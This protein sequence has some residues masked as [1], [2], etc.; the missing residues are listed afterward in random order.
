MSTCNICSTNI[1]KAKFP[2]VKCAGPCENTFHL[3]CANISDEL[4]EEIKNR[5][6]TWLCHACRSNTP[7]QSLIVDEEENY[8]STNN[9]PNLSDVM[10]LLQRMEKKLIALENM[11][12]MVLSLAS[13]NEQLTSRVNTL[14]K[15]L[16]TQ[17]SKIHLLEAEN[18]KPNQQSNSSSI[19]IIGLPSQHDDVRDVVINTIK[20]IG[21]EINYDDIVS[22]HAIPK[23]TSTVSSKQNK[24]N[25][26][27]HDLLVVKFTTNEIK[28]NIMLHMKKK[29]SIS[30]KDLDIIL[31][32]NHPEQRIFIM[33]RLTAF[34]SQL[35]REAKK[36]KS[37]YNY[38]YLWCNYGQIYLRKSAA[39]DVHRIQS[40]NDIFRLHD[41]NNPNGRK[42]ISG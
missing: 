25:S 36:I 5:S 29:K 21:L 30:T 28:N 26:L 38:K 37:T 40:H 2:G 17:T 39:S 4:V 19:T 23:N 41:T 27:L 8:D 20:K 14:E 12:A 1:T 6:A 34:Q 13:D 35:Y 15:Q 16:S 7:N 18:D 9:L 42:I 10:I 31:P 32:Q 3:K 33:H 11:K 22:I 24:S